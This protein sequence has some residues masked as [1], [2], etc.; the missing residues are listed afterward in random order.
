VQ[1]PADT[2]CHHACFA[3]AWACYHTYVLLFCHHGIPLLSTQ[4]P[5]EA[6]VCCLCLGQRVCCLDPAAAALQPGSLRQEA[7]GWPL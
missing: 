4:V 5:Q 1:Q 2:R 7:A 6:G 3:A